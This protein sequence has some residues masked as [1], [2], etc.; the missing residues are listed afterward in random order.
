MPNCILQWE[1]REVEGE[2]GREKGEEGGSRGGER[3]GGGG[4][5]GEGGGE[6]GG[7]EK[8]RGWE[9]ERETRRRVVD[10]YDLEHFVEVAL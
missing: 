10:A 2:G 7:G 6:R 5:G 8:R 4:G 1:G 3:G 9:E